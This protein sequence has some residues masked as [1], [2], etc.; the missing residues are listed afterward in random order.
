M[1]DNTVHLSHR[2]R[3][4]KHLCEKYPRW[5]QWIL[6]SWFHRR[7]LQL[8]IPSK[9][10]LKFADKSVSFFFQVDIIRRLDDAWEPRRL[11]D[12]DVK[13]CQLCWI[14]SA[15]RIRQIITRVFCQVMFPNAIKPNISCFSSWQQTETILKYG[16]FVS[17]Y[18]RKKY[19][20][21]KRANCLSKWLDFSSNREPS[22]V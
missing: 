17:N 22:A 9:I 11:C 15:E 19:F 14:P 18:F 5:K 12:F 21:Q 6:D 10:P 8:C 16:E 3:S 13:E 1:N 20:W 2:V 7:S 4:C